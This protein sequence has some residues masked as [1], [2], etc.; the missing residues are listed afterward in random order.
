MKKQYVMVEKSFLEEIE[1]YLIEHPHMKGDDK[2]IE[3]LDMLDRI[4]SDLS[5]G[6]I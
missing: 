2:Y 1:A 5:G 3:Y 4:K 6:R